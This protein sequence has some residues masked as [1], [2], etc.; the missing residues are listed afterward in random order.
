MWSRNNS[1]IALNEIKEESSEYT[2][3]DV[4]TAQKLTQNNGSIRAFT[5]DSKAVIVEYTG[6]DSS[7]PGSYL[8]LLDGTVNLKF[9]SG[10]IGFAYSPDGKQ[11]A[12][13][14][15]ARDF[16]NIYLMNA[17]GSNV[18]KLTNGNGNPKWS[19]DGRAIGFVISDGNDLA[20]IRDWWLQ[21][22]LLPSKTVK[23]VH[24]GK[25]VPD[26]QWSPV[27][28]S[29]I[30]TDKNEQGDDEILSLNLG[31]QQWLTNTIDSNF[32]PQWSP[33][34]KTIYFVSMR[35]GY[36]DIYTMNPAGQNQ[37]R[38]SPQP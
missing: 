28:N 9:L 17:D 15:L 18:Q 10:G 33:D 26:F 14:S 35:D 32:E 29:M 8:T 30:V 11:I 12:Y 3:L 13:R 37:Q 20:M 22:V 21:T 6:A 7:Q 23:L 16:E 1:L 4:H 19:A 38:L 34:E 24:Q 5:P 2:I 36:E 25:G 27:T 31:G